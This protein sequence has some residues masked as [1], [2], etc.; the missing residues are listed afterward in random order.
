[1]KRNSHPKD[2]R[3]DRNPSSSPH[4]ADNVVMAV[5]FHSHSSAANQSAINSKV[6]DKSGLLFFFYPLL[7]L[8]RKEKGGREKRKGRREKE[9]RE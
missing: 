4:H 1:M 3:T 8:R 5:S 6:N 9:Y 2:T 7:S